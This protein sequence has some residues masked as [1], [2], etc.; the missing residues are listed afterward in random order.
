MRVL[1]LLALPAMLAT[2]APAADPLPSFPALRA[3]LEIR[4]DAALD[5]KAARVVRRALGLLDAPA[6]SVSG[7]LGAVVRAAT[8]LER[9]FPGEFLA[10]GAPSD[11]GAILLI[12]LRPLDQTTE[13]GDRELVR[14]EEWLSDRGLARINR[15]WD[16]Y[17]RQ[18][19]RLTLDLPLGTARN[20]HYRAVFLDRSHAVADRDPGDG[21]LRRSIGCEFQL[22]ENIVP[23]EALRPEMTYSASDQSLRLQ[24]TW[25]VGVES[26]TWTLDLLVRGVVETGE[27]I[28]Q[29]PDVKGFILFERPGRLPVRYG[30][31]PAGLHDHFTVRNFDRFHGVSGSFQ[32]HAE[33]GEGNHLRLR[34][35]DFAFS[36]TEISFLP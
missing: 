7:R 26:G 18:R 24:G 27:W 30:I 34:G 31:L 21:F 33:D 3:E 12:D 14:R 1:L 28:L 29:D 15:L 23:F 22:E 19:S 8:L 17:L 4:G 16:V 10:E 5:P 32:F 13:F 9:V 2:P 11:L 36:A 6:R 25:T 20:L 35:G